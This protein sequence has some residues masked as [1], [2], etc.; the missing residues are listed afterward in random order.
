[1]TSQLIFVTYSF[2]WH[3]MKRSRS[4]RSEGRGYDQRRFIV[5]IP[6]II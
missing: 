1:M 6:K 3:K 2:N 4:D 5:C